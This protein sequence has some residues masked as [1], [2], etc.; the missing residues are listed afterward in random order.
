L[1]GN[2]AT[3][4]AAWA[5]LPVASHAHPRTKVAAANIRERARDFI[6]ATW[7]VGALSGRDLQTRMHSSG[8]GL[9]TYFHAGAVCRPMHDTAW[10]I[11]IL[12]I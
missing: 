11:S 1:I 10:Q 6:A 9:V 7:I 2:M 5:A 4:L 3:V 8:N 12:A